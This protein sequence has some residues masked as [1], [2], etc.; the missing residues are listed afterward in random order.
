MGLA[1]GRGR[2]GALLLA[3]ALSREER[4]LVSRRAGLGLLGLRLLAVLVLMAALF[5]PILARPVREADRGRVIVAVDVSASMETADP[6]RSPDERLRLARTLGLGPAEPV[7]SIS[8]R[9][10]A[11][12][13][14]GEAGSPVARIAAEHAVEVVA[15]A[16]EAVPA[17]LAS[18]AETL[19][20]PGPADDP[21]ALTTDWEPALAKGLDGPD[22]LPVVGIVLLTDGLRNAPGDPAATV[23]RLAA[24]GVPVYP[25]AIGA[26]T[27]PRDVAVAAIKAPPGVYKGDVAHVEATL[28]VDGYAGSEITV[29]LERP[30][31]SPMRQTVRA[32]HR[33]GAAGGRLRRPAR[34]GGEGAPDRFRGASRGRWGGF[35]VEDEAPHPPFGHPLPGGEG[36]EEARDNDRRTVSVQVSDARAEVLLVD[37]EARWEFRYLRN[38]LARDPR[39]ALEAVV[40]R[41]PGAG[42]DSPSTYGSA[43]RC[44]ARCAT[45]PTRWAGSTRS[46]SATSTRRICPPRPGRGWNR[47]SA[48]GGGLSS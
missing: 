7:D 9:E 41:Q 29:T 17:S 22:D 14:L 45:S 23:D 32:A 27:P 20:R 2:G 46:S 40:F 47:T 30:G 11:R 31:A 37:G 43:L 8:R 15:F 44:P 39:V 16:R 42:G 4:R 24:R 12:R 5:E 28:K 10:V 25:V 38:A 33:R 21:S 36:K 26:T 19:R 1:L 13:L 34:R 35:L 48:S 6:G 3:L 18:L